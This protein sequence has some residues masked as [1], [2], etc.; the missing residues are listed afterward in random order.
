MVRVLGKLHHVATRLT[1]TVNHLK[2]FVTEILDDS[3]IEKRIILKQVWLIEILLEY[4]S[5]SI[6]FV[7]A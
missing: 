7:T 3:S 1:S 2:E 6:L 5:E 4:M